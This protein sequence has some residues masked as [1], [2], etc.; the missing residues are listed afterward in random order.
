M[1]TDHYIAIMPIAQL[2]LAAHESGALLL[3]ATDLATVRE[4]YHC[5]ADLD[6]DTL[7]PTTRNPG[8]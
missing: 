4:A 7:W 3:S 1:T 8:A 5:G 2:I 6:L